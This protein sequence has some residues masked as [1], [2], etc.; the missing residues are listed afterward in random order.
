M[1]A[2]F[3]ISLPC[4]SVKETKNF[5][6]QTIGASIGRTADS[7]VDI[8]LFGNQITFI[9]AKKF[10]FINPNYVFEGKI[11]PSFHFGVI[12]DEK[13]WKE[14]YKKLDKEDLNLVDK[15]IFL[16]DKSGEHKSFFVKDPNDYM[17]EFKCFKHAKNV[18]KS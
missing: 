15:T 13:P 12:L 8:D 11:L 14:I 6:A 17:I 1:E 5:Y 3:H 2:A 7:W 16:K 18:F 9:R 10:N 4:I